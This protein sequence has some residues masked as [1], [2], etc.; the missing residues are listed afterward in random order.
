MRGVGGKLQVSQ[1]AMLKARQP[2]PKRGNA[3]AGTREAFRAGV[4]AHAAGRSS[5]ECSYK[6]PLYAACWNRGWFKA[7]E[8]KEKGK[9]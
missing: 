9:Q 8:I 7:A 6:N 1:D 3:V 2:E 4:N 5:N